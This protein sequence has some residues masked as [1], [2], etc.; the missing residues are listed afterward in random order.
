MR[1]AIPCVAEFSDAQQVARVINAV[2]G[3]LP[4]HLVVLAQ[5]A[6]QT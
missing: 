3:T 5:D 6:R 4:R 2:G 1:S